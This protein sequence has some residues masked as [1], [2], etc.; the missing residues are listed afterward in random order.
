MWTDGYTRAAAGFRRL[1]LAA[2]ALVVAGCTSVNSTSATFEGTSWQVTAV[3][4]QA[5][6]RSEEY[7]LQFENG[8][9]GGKLGCNHLG[10]GYRV[11]GDVMV[12]S[13]IAQ[14]L[15]GCPEPADTFERNG[16]AVLQQPMRLTWHSDRQLTLSN[17]AGSIALERTR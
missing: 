5:T 12:A 6:P 17:A 1:R 3:N 16:T 4:G 7:R 2:A 15:M 9:I 8:R 10:G 14:T 11:Q 13:D